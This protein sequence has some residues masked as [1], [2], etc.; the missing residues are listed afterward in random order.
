M[1]FRSGSAALVVAIF[2]ARRWLTACGRWTAVNVVLA[3]L[4]AVAVPITTIRVVTPP[5]D[6]EPFRPFYDRGFE[7]TVE[8][9]NREAPEGAVLLAP[10]DMG[11]YYRGRFYGLEPVL[12][13]VGMPGAARVAALPEVRV[14]VDSV[15]YPVVADPDWFKQFGVVRVEAV[16]DY[17]IYVK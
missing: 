3:G 2:G 14:L 4:L 6:R 1:L 16:G 9:L 12:A 7:A 11:H 15:R 10:K 5:L 13:A 8:W 17:R